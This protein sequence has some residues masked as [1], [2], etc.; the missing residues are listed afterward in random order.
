MEDKK[1]LEDL[2]NTMKKLSP[3]LSVYKDLDLNFTR[4]RLGLLNISLYLSLSSL[5]LNLS[6]LQFMHVQ[7][8]FKLMTIIINKKVIMEIHRWVT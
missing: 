7:I 8:N 5:S 2:D 1:L 6:K 4:N 3:G